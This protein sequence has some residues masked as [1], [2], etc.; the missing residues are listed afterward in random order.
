MSKPPG[1]SVALTGAGGI[2]LRVT[3]SDR[4]ADKVWDA[5]EDAIDAG[6]TVE[7]F[8]REAAECWDGYM[9]EKRKRDADAWRKP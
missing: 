5:V 3:P 1:L 9:S 8:R 2:S 6:W 7:R 4:I